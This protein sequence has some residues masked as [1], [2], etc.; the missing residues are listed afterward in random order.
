MRRV[1]LGILLLSA[2]LSARAQQ[3]RPEFR[4]RVDGF[5][6][7][8]EFD[9]SGNQLASSNTLAGIVAKPYVGVR[10]GKEHR[11]MGGFSALQYFGT[12]GQGPKLEGALWYQY[13]KGVFTLAAGIFPRSALKGAYSTAI[14][15]DG[16]RL[17]DAHL[18][19]FLLQWHKDRSHYEIALDWNGKYGPGRREQFNVITSGDG[20]VTP[21]L[22]LGWEGMFHHYAC[23]KEAVD[24][25]DD[26][27][28]HPYVKADFA[29]FTGLQT[30]SVQ[31]GV[32]A[33]F[34]R[35]RYMEE[36]ARLPLGV[37]LT[38]TAMKWGFG[39]RNQFYYGNSQAPY[40]RE[41]DST[42]EVFGSHLYMRSSF[43]QIRTDGASAGYYDRADLFW[44][45]NLGAY[46]RLAVQL[47][48]YFGQGGYVGCQ[49]LLHATVNLDKITFKHKK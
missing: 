39:L 13:D 15:S 36:T 30:L 45:K 49:Q 9:V 47:R 3:V 29:S 25:V 38:V 24:V 23:S 2:F 12:P 35:N 27:L 33:G 5:F 14:V 11:L 4:V 10:F 44:Q 46:V 41:L 16:V 19:G 31:A 42:G 37:N 32:M 21:W 48:F 8:G 26:H 20:W 43:W 22:A 17:V 1:L 6:L 18:E 34:Q 40:Y 7:N 28:L